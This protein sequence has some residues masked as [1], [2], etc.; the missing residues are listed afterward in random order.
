MMHRNRIKTVAVRFQYAILP[1]ADFQVGTLG[2]RADFK[3]A[4]FSLWRDTSENWQ[5]FLGVSRPTEYLSSYVD[6]NGK[7]LLSMWIATADDKQNVAPERWQQLVAVLF[8]L[9]WVRI[10][11]MTA[12]RAAA[13]DFYFEAFSVPEGAPDDS[14]SHVRWSKYGAHFWSNLEIHPSPEVSVH[15][16]AIDL[17]VA[18]VRNSPFFD[19]VPGDLFRALEGE[20]NKDASRLLS[21]L[22]FLQQSA[23]RSAS[24]SSYAEDIQNICTAF[25]ALLDVKDKGD[26]AD[27]VSAALTDLFRTQAATTID[28][29]VGRPPD[30][31]VPEVLEQLVKW[32]TKLYEIRNSYTHGKTVLDYFLSRRSVWQD[33][34]EI[35]RLAANRVILGRPE[36]RSTDGSVLE[37][38]LM[39]VQYFDE[40]VALLWDRDRWFPG[41]KKLGTGHITLDDAIRKGRVLDPGLV[42]AINS[43]GHLRQAL[44]NIC[45]AIWAAVEDFHEVECDSRKVVV[46]LGEFREAYASSLRPKIDVDEFIRKIAPRLTMWVPN[47]PLKGSSAP[48]FELIQAFKNLLAVYGDQT[49][50]ILNSLANTLP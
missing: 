16:H 32:T 17:P 49:E 15:G 42:E 34:F 43:L 19:P 41:G 47:I 28:D 9:A 26:S 50:P 45:M 12:D 5:R 29:I 4:K 1:Y 30:P 13:E 46:I 20:L 11:Y 10:P 33:A 2:K 35:F 48:L 36:R 18:A 6:R 37:R 40:V 39:S 24:R 27:Q 7:P 8:Y 14:R 25:E 31:E 22:W 44:F 21:A 38:R 23:F 3:V